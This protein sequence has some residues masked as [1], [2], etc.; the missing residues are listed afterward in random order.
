[1]TAYSDLVEALED[2]EVVEALMFGPWGWGVAPREGNKWELGYDEPE[3]APVPFEK[4]G[5]VLTL[6]EAKPYMQSWDFYG[7][8]GAPDCY[9]AYI[10]TNHRVIWVTQ[11]DGATTL[12]SAPRNPCDTM[13]EMPGG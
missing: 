11:Y 8:Y 7:G 13:P 4:R 10:W 6:D 1:M 2:G 3:P 12:S 5:V 9:A